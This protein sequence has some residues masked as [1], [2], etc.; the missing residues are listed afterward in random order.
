[1]AGALDDVFVGGEFVEADG[2]AGVEAV[3]AASDLSAETE[4]KSVGE[5]GAG[6]DENGSRVDSLR[7]FGCGVEVA[8]DDGVC[9]AA[10]FF[11]YEI[12]GIIE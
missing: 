7:E 4:F 11:I 3:G 1:M 9:V 6:G 10:A 12:D 8:G 5:A 2:A